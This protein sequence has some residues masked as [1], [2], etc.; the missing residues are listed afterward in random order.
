MN[1][2]ARIWTATVAGLAL[3]VLL[4]LAGSA[5][6]GVSHPA[7]YSRVAQ[8]AVGWSSGW[9]T[10]TPNMS[11]TLNHNLGGDPGD[12]A[13]ELWF[14]DDEAN[15]HGI[16]TRAYGGLE[17]DGDY[18]GA[19]WHHLTSDSIQ[20][21]RLEDDT[22]ADQVRLRV[23]VPDPAPDYC[24]AWTPIGLG[25]TLT[26]S[27]GL[28]GDVD[29]YAVRL[30]FSST[31]RGITHFAY[32]GLEFNA[33]SARLGAFWHNL[34]S[35]TVQVFRFPGGGEAQVRVC[36][37]VPDPPDYD[38]G[39]VTV[40]QGTTTTFQHNLNVHPNML[41]VRLSAKSANADMGINSFAAGGLNDNSSPQGFN[42]E[43]LTANSVKVVRYAD[44]EHAGQ[45]RVRIWSG[46]RRVYLPLA[47][48]D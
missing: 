32:G 14:M 21:A 29:D 37:T 28:G 39:W 26:F 35:S 5:T 19:Y 47:R 25:E 20:L 15:G 6:A 11:A 45:V 24:S 9:I 22:F 7:P 31:R 27:H 42:W 12:Y 16:N 8:D 33:G 1:K 48:R 38:S 44:D 23:W 40:T 13:V 17:A 36:V 10:V 4:L 30:T 18:Y 41:G 46:V 3:A 43:N 2:Q 34:T